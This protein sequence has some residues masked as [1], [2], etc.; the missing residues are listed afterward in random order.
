[1]NQNYLKRIHIFPFQ[2][3]LHLV[4]FKKKNSFGCGQGVHPPPPFTD[5]SAT[6]MFFVRLPLGSTLGFNRE[7]V[8]K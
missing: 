3:I 2:N 5:Q 7:A 8:E 4:L 6:N 1:M